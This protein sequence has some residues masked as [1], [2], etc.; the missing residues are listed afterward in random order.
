MADK[1]G[2]YVAAFLMAGSVGVFGSLVPFVLLCTKRKN[3]HD[4]QVEYLEELM[5]KDQNA[6]KKYNSA[7]KNSNPAKITY[8]IELEP[9]KPVGMTVAHSASSKRPVSFMCAMENPF[10]FL[11]PKRECECLS[12]KYSKTNGTSK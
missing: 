7:S 5:D 1:F 11:P 9:C 4:R 3:N 2:N 10:N 8:H 12:S 6:E